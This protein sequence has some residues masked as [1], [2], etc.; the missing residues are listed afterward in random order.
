[1]DYEYTNIIFFLSSYSSVIND[2]I[3]KQLG[4][5]CSSEI[6]DG[7]MANERLFDNNLVT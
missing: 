2:K 3:Y 7:Y 4:K 6:L 1:M 5:V